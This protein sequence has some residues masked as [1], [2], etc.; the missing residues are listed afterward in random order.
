MINWYNKTKALLV[1]L[2]ITFSF[3]AQAGSPDN[4]KTLFKANCAAC[5]AK[6]MKTKVLGPGLGDM[7]ANWSAYPKEDFYKW[8]RNSQG[9]IKDG[10]PR[11]KELWEEFKPIPMTPFPDMK[12]S[13]IED[14]IAYVSSVVGG[15]AG[16]SGGSLDKAGFDSGKGLFKAN[17]AACHAKDMKSAALGPALGGVVKRWADYPKEDLY[18]WI[19]D[20]PSMIKSGHKKANEVWEKFKPIPMTPFPN[21]KDDE[22]KNILTFIEGT[23]DGSYEVK[24]KEV[25]VEEVV[26]EKSTIN[27]M[28]YGLLGFLALFAL[29]LWNII[30]KL[31]V[32]NRIDENGVAEQMPSFFS[33]LNSKQAWSV[34]SFLFLVIGGYF[35]VVNATN[36]G[37]QQ[38]YAPIQPINFS[39]KIHAGDNKIDC[40]YCHDG[41][42]RSKHSVIP[43]MNTCM[44]CHAA[45]K[46]GS[47]DGTKELTKIYA[48][49][50][51]NPSTGKYIE[52]YENMKEGDIKDI[53]TKWIASNN[54][55]DKSDAIVAEQWQGIK[56]ALT[57]EQKPTIPGAVEWKRIHNLPDHVYY[58]HSQHVNVAGLDCTVCHGKVEE[59][60]VVEQY[61]TLGMGWCI[62]CHRETE[63]P[64]FED[65]E[66]YKSYTYFHKQMN[67]GKRSKVTVADIGGLECAKCHY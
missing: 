65:S 10:H 23:Y 37:R 67:E 36:L 8:I 39:H 16:A 30:S 24:K 59:M 45:I 1:V 25:V 6:D 60:D 52:D 53:F 31:N 7:M 54:E 5:H 63:V 35:T 40:Q 44:N 2:F 13:D 19:K 17:C 34:Y 56:D 66:Y 61:S 18:S 47:K 27:W 29:I 9:M 46:V 50:G 57:H 51:Y 49:V 38:G 43:A 15:G 58:N 20:S 26:E 14:I 4:G 55:G 22:I 64:G 11:A 33:L 42:R 21:L 28:L 32:L 41:A 3:A 48:S 62:N 12:D